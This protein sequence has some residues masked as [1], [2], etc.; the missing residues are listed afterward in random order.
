VLDFVDAK[1]IYTNKYKEYAVFDIS[2]NIIL[3]TCPVNAGFPSPA[4]DYVE[5][6][7]DLNVH[8]VRHP[9]ATFFVRAE[10]DSMTGAGIFNGD[11]LVVD[12]SL[13]AKNRNVV[14][15]VVNGEFT[16][17]RLCISDGSVSLVAENPKYK[18]IAIMDG[19]DFRIWGVVTYVIHKL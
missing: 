17:K 6:N 8:L 3:F 16:V 9:A 13:N 4:A 12:R 2:E 15:A 19:M 11:I 7:L 14:I 1:I 5:E 10:G 18:P